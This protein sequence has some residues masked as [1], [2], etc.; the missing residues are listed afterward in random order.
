MTGCTSQLDPPRQ[1]ATVC[2]HTS[3]GGAAAPNVASS[4]S[5]LARAA[6]NA[7][8]ACRCSSP[9]AQ[10]CRISQPPVPW[11]LQRPSAA[12][13]ATWNCYRPKRSRDRHQ[14]EPARPTIQLARPDRNGKT[15]GLK[16]AAQRLAP[17]NRSRVTNHKFESS[18][19]VQGHLEHRTDLPGV[20]GELQSSRRPLSDDCGRPCD[21]RVA[22]G[23]VGEA[24][25]QVVES[26]K[27]ARLEPRRV[28]QRDVARLPS[29]STDSRRSRIPARRGQSV[30]RRG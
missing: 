29:W 23:D 19:H 26:C 7:R 4:S 20:R 30:S 18:G 27:P 22:L 17:S 5:T 15:V 6:G 24:S 9:S 12:W 14:P 8:Q 21:A 25:P 13:A 11:R 16:A 2:N 28:L 3:A 1:R 10:Q